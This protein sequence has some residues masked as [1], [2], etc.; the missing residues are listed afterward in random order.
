M[1]QVHGDVDHRYPRN[2][3]YPMG[4]TFDLAD[5][6]AAI[7][8]FGSVTDLPLQHTID[9]LYLVWNRERAGGLTCGPGQSTRVHRCECILW[10]MSMNSFC[11]LGH[12]VQ[13]V[14]RAEI[15]K[16]IVPSPTHEAV[17]QKGISMPRP[18]P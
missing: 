3:S 8:E 13:I 11:L 17:L 9:I 4:L 15:C 18:R 10:M 2:R 5:F 16:L 7:A 12:I 14:A 1:G 6:P